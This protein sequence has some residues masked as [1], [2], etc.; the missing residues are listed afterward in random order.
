MTALVLN[1]PAFN[2][3]SFC[4]D[5]E[6]DSPQEQGGFGVLGWDRDRVW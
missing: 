4:C 1:L 6:P 5:Y 2:P 3:R